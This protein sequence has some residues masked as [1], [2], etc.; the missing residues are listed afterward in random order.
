MRNWLVVLVAALLLGTPASAAEPAVTGENI[1]V[2]LPHG[3]RMAFTKRGPVNQITEFVPAGETLEDWSQ[4]VTEVTLFGVNNADPNV[5]GASMAKGWTSACPGGVA[6]K[7]TDGVERGYPIALWMYRCPLNPATQKPES[8][9]LKVISGQ[10]SL[11]QVQYAY[12]RLATMEMIPPTTAY[13]KRIV[14][15]DSR[16]PDRACPKITPDARP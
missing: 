7:V 3:F 14:V 15:C 5:L 1:L 4:M 11:Y 13:L 2:P 8:M 16:R 9:W 6:T 12:R 10:D